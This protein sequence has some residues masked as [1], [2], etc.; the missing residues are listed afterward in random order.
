MDVDLPA[1]RDLE[2]VFTPATPL[3]QPE[4]LLGRR[5]DLDRAK[6]IL[7][8]PGRHLLILG[9][10]GVGRTSLALA[11]AHGRPYRYHQVGLGERF[12]LLLRRLLADEPGTVAPAAADA[13][14][15]LVDQPELAPPLLII[16]D[17]HQAAGDTLVD[18]LVPLLRALSDGD[19]RTKVILTAR[20]DVAFPVPLSQV[21]LRLFAMVIDRLD[22]EDLEQVVHAG[23]EA[24]GLDFTEEL[25]ARLVADADGLPGL[26]HALALEAARSARR[27]GSRRVTLGRDYLPALLA[28]VSGLEPIL[29]TEYATAAGGRGKHQRYEHVLWAAALGR[30][31]TVSLDT[32]QHHLQLIEGKPMPRQAFLPHLGDLLKHGVLQRIHEGCY[33]LASPAMRVYIRLKLRTERPALLGEDPLQLALPY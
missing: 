23:A 21:G 8:E 33:R 25:T 29:A 9:E 16:D 11:C 7:A 20:R 17:V 30:E 2:T 28:L 19:S 10:P 32:L 6:G 12:E 1:H 4:R 3:T 18:G 31:S 24:T 5:H 26:V 15:A 27:R 13:V 14:W 22:P